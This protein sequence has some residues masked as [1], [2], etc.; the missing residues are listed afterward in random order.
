MKKTIALILF[1]APA[2]IFA[3]CYANLRDEGKELMRRQDYATALNR[4]WA[5]MDHCPDAPDNDEM[6]N[7][8]K[9]AQERWV[10]DLEGTVQREKKARQEAVV[11]KEQAEQARAA[12]ELARKDLEVKERLAKERGLRAETL[13]LTL[14]ADLVRERGRKS[15]ALALAYLAMQLSG[16]NT[17]PLVYRSFGKAVRDSFT[18]PVFSAQSPITVLEPFDQGRHWLVKA[19]NDGYW[20]LQPEKG[21]QLLIPAE[22]AMGA[23]AAPSS[24][25]LLTWGKEGTATLWKTDG[26]SLAVVRGHTEA[27]RH[28]D[29]APD[30]KRLATASRDNTA[31]IWD[32]Q[33]ALLATLQ[34]HTGNVYEVR[35]SPDGQRLL[36]RSSDGT[37]RVWDAQG[38]PLGTLSQPN[39][40]LYEA[41]WSP[42]GRGIACLFADGS[43][44]LWTSDG[45]SSTVLRPSGATGIGF[46]GQNDVM[47]YGGDKNIYWFKGGQ[48]NPVVLQQGGVPTGVSSAYSPHA[49]LAWDAVGGLNLWNANGQTSQTLVGHRDAILGAVCLPEGGYT[50]STAKDE[51]AKLWDNQ[52][53]LILEWPLGSATSPMAR[54]GPDGR[55]IWVVN[56]KGKTLSKTPLP[57]TIYSNMS[58]SNDAMEQLVRQYNVEL[59]DILL[60]KSR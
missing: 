11:A 20:V 30:G 60:G 15:D 24:P 31:R 49:L 13:R 9:E 48:G 26:T 27:I 25:L 39:G 33:G 53:N 41:H 44:R 57:E 6:G 10:R 18:I 47:V 2:A 4:F 50:L 21:T 1:F 36:T 29:F 43:A 32:L 45:Q 34:G 52:G 35:F 14:L 51:T 55:T 28:A 3:Q 56:G 58:L 19:G 37:A 8:I 59:F 7:L 54:F 17:D 23:V 38:Q 16:A 22:G 40:Y 5:A 12:E 42:S 46:A